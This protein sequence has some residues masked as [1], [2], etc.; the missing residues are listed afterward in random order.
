[1]N[2]LK[3]N[4]T[5]WLIVGALSLAAAGIGVADPALYEGVVDSSIMPAFVICAVMALR[6]RALGLVLSVLYIGKLK[7]T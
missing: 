6:R 4:R 7:R 1:M 3:L 2:N 5:L